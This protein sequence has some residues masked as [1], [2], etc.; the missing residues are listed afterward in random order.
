MALGIRKTV[1]ARNQRRGPASAHS[2]GANENRLA[3]NQT[4]VMERGGGFN[5]NQQQR[6]QTVL[7]NHI[8]FPNC[9]AFIL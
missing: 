7:C 4:E 6:Y 8:L 2:N 3:V 1:A 9:L 5:N